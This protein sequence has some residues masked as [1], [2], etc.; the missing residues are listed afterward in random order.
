MWFGALDIGEGILHDIKD[1]WIF[2]KVICTI[3][4]TQKGLVMSIKIYIC[5]LVKHMKMVG[6]GLLY[7]L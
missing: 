1:V 3:Y 7:I 5:S 2:W 6:L 4:T